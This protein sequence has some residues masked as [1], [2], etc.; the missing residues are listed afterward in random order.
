MARVYVMNKEL[1]RFLH[2]DHEHKLNIISLGTTILQKNKA[3]G[4]GGVECIFRVS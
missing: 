2:A 3:K 1:S 4:S